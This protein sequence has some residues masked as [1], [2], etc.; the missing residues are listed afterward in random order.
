MIGQLI[1]FVGGFKNKIASL[2]KT[3]APKKSRVQ[4]RKE[5]MQT[6][7]TKQN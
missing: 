5:T 6:K 1:I 7:N 4:E 2:F 3:N